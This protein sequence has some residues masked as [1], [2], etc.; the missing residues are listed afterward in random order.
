[1]L[2]HLDTVLRAVPPDRTAD[3]LVGTGALDM[4]GGFAAFLGAL[5]LLGESGEDPPDDLIVVGVPDEEV[6][7]PISEDV[8]RRWG[9]RHGR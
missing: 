1:M 3:R 6:G 4:K 5:R 8:V 7:G 9:G 2:G